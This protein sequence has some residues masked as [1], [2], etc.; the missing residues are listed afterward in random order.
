MAL[1]GALH[2]TNHPPLEP[3]S[4][5]PALM[6]P[7]GRS[8]SFGSPEV[9]AS[10]PKPSDSLPLPSSPSPS[11]SLYLA[12]KVR[13]L[14]NVFRKRVRHRSQTARRRADDASFCRDVERE[15]YREIDRYLGRKPKHN[16]GRRFGEGATKACVGEKSKW[17]GSTPPCE[18]VDV[19]R[20]VICH[21][22]INQWRLDNRQ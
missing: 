20:C 6:P 8:L 7:F 3:S 18:G 11:S 14:V 22:E 16:R 17:T 10:V 13:S 12:V 15:A 19:A 2:T 4:T 5:P 1:P 9:K 21:Y